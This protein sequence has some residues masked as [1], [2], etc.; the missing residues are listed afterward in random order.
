MLFLNSLDLPMTVIEGFNLPSAVNI[1]VTSIF[2]NGLFG[3]GSLGVPSTRVQL[4][5]VAFQPI[6]L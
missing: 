2:A 4:P 1:D 6:I 3:F 5:T